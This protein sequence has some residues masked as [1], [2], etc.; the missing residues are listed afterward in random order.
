MVKRHCILKHTAL[1]APEADNTGLAKGAPNGFLRNS[2]LLL[3]LCLGQSVL[4]LT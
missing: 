2:A 1:E 3:G 4:Y